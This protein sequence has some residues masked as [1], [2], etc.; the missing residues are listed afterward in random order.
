MPSAAEKA[1]KVENG[2]RVTSQ[3]LEAD[4]AQLKADIAKLAKQLQVTGEHSYGTARRVASESVSQLKAQSD[5]AMDKMRSNASDFEA[6]LT[7][8][9]REKPLTALGIAAGVG[10]ILA[11]MTR[12]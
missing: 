3:N 7:A 4:V 5:A 12:R 9:V 10:F 11:L 6:Q 1:A 2:S 8:S